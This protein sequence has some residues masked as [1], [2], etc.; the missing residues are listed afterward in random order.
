MKVDPTIEMQSR[1]M[2]IAASYPLADLDDIRNQNPRINGGIYIEDFHQEFPEYTQS[3]Y[4][5]MR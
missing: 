4:I 3:S 2:T 5:Q 1:W